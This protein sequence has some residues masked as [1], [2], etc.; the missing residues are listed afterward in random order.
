MEYRSLENADLTTVLFAANGAGGSFA[1]STKTPQEILEDVNALLSSTWANSA[2]EEWCP[3]TWETPIS[4]QNSLVGLTPYHCLLERPSWW[5]PKAPLLIPLR[6]YWWLRR[7][8]IDP[9]L[10]GRKRRRPEKFTRR[11]GR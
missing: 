11:L 3:L 4:E 2:N 7:D 1:W 8:M 9:L 5:L 6:A 10:R